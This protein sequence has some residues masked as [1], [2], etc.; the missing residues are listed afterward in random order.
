MK[1]SWK[2]YTKNYTGVNLNLKKSNQFI[3]FNILANYISPKLILINLIFNQYSNRY[4]N[5][6]NLVIIPL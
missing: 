5:P 1:F 3:K 6:S 2:F 4:S